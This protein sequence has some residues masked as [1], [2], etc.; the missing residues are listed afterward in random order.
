MSHSTVAVTNPNESQL[1]RKGNATPLE[2]PLISK[3]NVGS[4]G[5]LLCFPCNQHHGYRLHHILG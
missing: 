1:E 3:R 2:L 4:L 5:P